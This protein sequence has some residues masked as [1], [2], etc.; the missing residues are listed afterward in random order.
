VW[1]T[2]ARLLEEGY[3]RHEILHMLGR[4]VSDQV[5]E[6]LH[7]ERPYDRERHVAALRALLAL[8][9]LTDPDS[10]VTSAN[11]DSHRHLRLEL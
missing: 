5:W 1:A 3:E 6:A 2:A 9:S 11:G 8:G 7:E 4:P 10:T